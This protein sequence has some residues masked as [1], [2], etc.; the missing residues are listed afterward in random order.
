MVLS[1]LCVAVQGRERRC[2]T[3]GRTEEEKR[4]CSPLPLVEAA[5]PRL[6]LPRNGAVAV[7]DSR[8]SCCS[9]FIIL[10]FTVT[11]EPSEFSAAI[12]A[13]VRSIWKLLLCHS[14]LFIMICGC[15]RDPCGCLRIST[16]AAD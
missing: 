5:P 10:P 7:G 12:K 16:V 6:W 11:A 14:I 3:Q 1:L 15:C 8:Q 2:A 13:A 9:T 4:R